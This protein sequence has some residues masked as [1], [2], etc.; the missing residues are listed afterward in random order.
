M[1]RSLGARQGL[2]KQALNPL[3]TVQPAEI[4]FVSWKTP[5]FFF[6]YEV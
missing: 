1:K 5:K 2:L 4:F 6:F 3:S